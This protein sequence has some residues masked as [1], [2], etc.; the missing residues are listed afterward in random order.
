MQIIAKGK[1]KVSKISRLKAYYNCETF[2]ASTVFLAWSYLPETHNW[3]WMLESKP[4]LFLAR[5]A[6]EDVL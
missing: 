4:Q 2:S 6:V 1:M 5:F 3:I